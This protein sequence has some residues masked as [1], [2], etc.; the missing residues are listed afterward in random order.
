[1]AMQTSKESKQEVDP[2]N[3][4]IADELEGM[5]SK[6]ESSNK[7]GYSNL[8]DK[9]KRKGSFS[10][11]D[12]N[13]N[14]EQ[15]SKYLGEKAKKLSHEE[16]I[17]RQ[18]LERKKLQQ[19]NEKNDRNKSLLD[20]HKERKNRDRDEVGK[21]GKR[22]RKEFDRSKDL[23]SVGSMKNSDKAFNTLSGKVASEQGLLSS[24]FGSSGKFL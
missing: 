8:A 15:S 6:F 1:M 19:Y 9:W 4:F 16:E 10:S 22:E 2:D 12:T 23:R 18:Q 14:Q 21:G 7:K 3:K 24:R 17:E 13:T 11:E 5:F 20:Q